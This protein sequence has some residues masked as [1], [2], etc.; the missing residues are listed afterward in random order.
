MAR[1]V[2][3]MGFFEGKPVYLS[4]DACI[5]Y[6]DSDPRFDADAPALPL[7]TGV[8][9]SYEFNSHIPHPTAGTWI[10]RVYEG[11][12]C[13]TRDSHGKTIVHDIRWDEDTQKR[14]WDVCELAP[15]QLPDF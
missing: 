4:P 8:V 5:V 6:G 15:D 10:P 2:W 9:Y 3:S 11:Y 7:S 1:T 14:H 13:L 12:F